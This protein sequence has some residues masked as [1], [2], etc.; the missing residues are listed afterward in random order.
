MYDIPELS[1]E[2]R[3]SLGISSETYGLSIG[4]KPHS[5]ELAIKDWSENNGDDFDQTV[6]SY[7]TLGSKE[8]PS[9]HEY[10]EDS[11][12]PH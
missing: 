10:H 8:Y 5:E 6:G 4:M 7:F 9:P 1:S 12:L 3:Q 11:S 2:Q